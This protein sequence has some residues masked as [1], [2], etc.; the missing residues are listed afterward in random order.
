MLLRAVYYRIVT[1]EP[2]SSPPVRGLPASFCAGVLLVGTLVAQAPARLARETP[3]LR[4]PGGLRLATL[5]PGARIARGRTSGEFA[6]VTLE[7]WIFTASTRPDRR[8]GFDLS[9]RAAGG[10][11]LRAAP[12]GQ[13]LARATEG[14]LFSRVG[15]R[16][17]W[18]RVRRTG[19]IA[20]AALTAM[21]PAP[22][23][24]PRRATAAEPPSAPPPLPAESSSPPA[25]P[26]PGTGPFRR[27]SPAA[28]L[29]PPARDSA[30][31]RPVQESA[32]AERRGTLRRGAALQAAPDGPAIAT[33]VSPGEVSV[34]GTDRQWARVRLEGWVPL[35]EIAGRVATRPAITGAMLRDNPER[36]VGQTV[37]WRLQFLARQQADELRPEI[38]LGQPYLLARGPLPE[39]GFVYLMVSKAQDTELR[40]LKPLDEIAVT[41]TVRAARTRYLATPVV[42]LVRL[43]E[44]K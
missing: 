26:V 25:A 28:A 20:R 39:S 8:D 17:G 4:E 36:Y 35:R 13:L 22:E 14:A 10:E 31:A 9:V 38:P 24:A 29:R 41:A 33:L 44:H 27:D 19:W 2:Q 43:A 21:A 11:N 7:A 32:G 12:D 34:V 37:Q 15:A 1:V 3:F 23:P 6:E 42:E 18:T 5:A 30:A 40:G 16:G